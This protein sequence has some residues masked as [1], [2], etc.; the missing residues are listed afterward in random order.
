MRNTTLQESDVHDRMKTITF[1]PE[2]LES[3]AGIPDI[4]TA[5]SVIEKAAERFE[6]NYPA[7]AVVKKD[8]RYGGPFFEVTAIMKRHGDPD[9]VDRGLQ[10]MQHWIFE[11]GVLDD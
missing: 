9:V 2:F 1:T 11:R 8:D 5:G 7:I 3:G 4:E 6:K 10:D